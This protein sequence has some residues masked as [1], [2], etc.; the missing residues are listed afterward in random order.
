MS[1][2]HDV[3]ATAC[4]FQIEGEFARGTTHGSGHINDSYCVTFHQ[5]RETIDATISSIAKNAFRPPSDVLCLPQS[6]CCACCETSMF[7]MPSMWC[8]A[9]IPGIVCM[10]DIPLTSVMAALRALRAAS[11]FALLVA[12]SCFAT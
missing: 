7:G 9:G 6:K 8:E 5:A 2:E 12:Q 1:R 4:Q 10:V 3:S 11:S